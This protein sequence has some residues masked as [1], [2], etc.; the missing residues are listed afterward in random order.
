LSSESFAYST[1]YDHN[2]IL[3]VKKSDGTWINREIIPHIGNTE[4][5][6]FTA[7][8]ADSVAWKQDGSVWMVNFWAGSPQKI[9]QSDTNQLLD[10]AFSRPKNQLLLNCTNEEGQFLIRY[11]L[12]SRRTDQTEL[13]DPE[14][15]ADNKVFVDHGAG[16]GCLSNDADG[17][18]FWFKL[19]ADLQPFHVV[20]PG[21]IRNF[22]LVDSRLFFTG[23]A[24]FDLPGI[25]EYDLDSGEFRSIVPGVED[26]FKYAHTLEQPFAGFITNSDALKVTYW[27]WRPTSPHNFKKHPV[28]ITNRYWN[29]FPYAQIA[30]NENWSAPVEIW[31]T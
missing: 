23:D 12:D 6:N 21:W 16:Y 10:F 20:W 3:V 9:W 2:I 28:I 14:D 30:V 17:G 31:T 4:L 24:D 5:E 1:S 27:L 26:R 13:N 18:N 22:T 7:I 15:L 8:S 19:K 25:W 11:N 29:L